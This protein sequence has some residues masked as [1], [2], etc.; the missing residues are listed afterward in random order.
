MGRTLKGDLYLLACQ[1][2]AEMVKQVIVLNEKELVNIHRTFDFSKKEIFKSMIEGLEE[3]M[4][5]G[6]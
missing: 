5:L 2:A 6:E 3:D 1:T 4:S